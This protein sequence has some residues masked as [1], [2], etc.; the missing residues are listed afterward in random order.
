MKFRPSTLQ[1][2]KDLT[3]VEWHTGLSETDWQSF[4]RLASGT[5]SGTVPL[6]HISMWVTMLCNISSSFISSRSTMLA[7]W[8]S[9]TLWQKSCL[10]DLI[11]VPNERTLRSPSVLVAIAFPNWSIL[12]SSMDLRPSMA[13]SV[14]FGLRPRN[15]NFV[16]KP[17]HPRLKD[18]PVFDNL[19][20]NN[21]TFSFKNDHEIFHAL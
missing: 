11:L 12:W 18:F 4:T 14:Y 1:L 6:L 19:L 7:S 2:N 15:P 20:I 13:S 3:E 5:L 17:Y 9:R 16:R 10:T 8:I 21:T